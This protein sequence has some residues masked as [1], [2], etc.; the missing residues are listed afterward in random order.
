MMK[1]N[2]MGAI[3]LL[4]LLTV[5]CATVELN[6]GTRTAGLVAVI[7]FKLHGSMI[8]AELTVDGSD[9]VAFIFDTAAGGTIISARIADRLH[10]IG[11]DAV[12]R[13]GATGAAQ[14]LR[15][16]KHIVS[17]GDLTLRNVTLGIAELD[18]IDRRLGMRIDGVIGWAILS[19]YAVRLDY[20]T[21]QIEIYDTKRFDYSLDVQGYDVEVTGT[22]VFINVTVAFKRGATFTGRVMVDT[23]SGGSI[24]FNTPFSR[25]NDLLTEIGCNYERVTQS[26]STESSRIFIAMLS[27]LSIGRHEFAGV[28]ASI[29][30]AETGA[31]SWPRVIGILGNGILKRFNM[32]IDLQQQRIFLEPNW[33][34]HE[35]FEVN[36]SGLELV[37]DD[38]LHKVI[39]DHVY[40]TSP[41]DEAGLKVGD[42]IVQIDGARASYLQLPR[43]R[44]M[45][46]QD[47]DK[48]EVLVNREG[49][50]YS[51]FL[52]LRPL[53]E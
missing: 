44:S 12:S 32:F 25:E 27:G 45:L 15:S 36:C 5:S 42:E 35:V 31:L 53:I 16:T 21:M 47:G 50:L 49:K 37:M 10:I 8:V 13:E 11:E 19:Q 22:V 9:P 17:V 2:V 48:I 43:I 14:I 30:F 24:S 7:P 23:G 28:P 46:S 39:V 18:H 29:A 3:C 38:T 6:E 40:V 52:R 33:L 26:L 4:T 1:R 51:Y 34:Y 41:A 20:D